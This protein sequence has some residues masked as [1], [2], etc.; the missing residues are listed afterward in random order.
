VG[1][2]RLLHE[3]G[4]GGQAV[5]WLAEDTRIGRRVALK[6]LPELGPGSEA[7]L[8][9]FRREAE[10]TSRLEHPAICPV[11]EADLARG[12]PFIA[13][14]FVDGETLA[15]RIART[16]AAGSGPVALTGESAPD[17]TGIATFF[18]RIARALHLAHEAGVV[19]R[20]IKPANLM[21]T[22]Q[23]EPVILDFGL[24]R[25]DD[26][27]SH[28]LTLSAQQSGT[29][30]YM[31]PEQMTGRARPDRRSDVYSLGCTLFECL[32][33]RPP[34]VAPTLEALFHAVLHDD[35]PDARGL[36]RGIPADLAVITATA[37][38]K[39]PE[40]RYKTALDMALDLERFARMEPIAA[41]PV[42][43]LQRA[44]R[45]SRRNQALAASLGAVL[46]LLML[47]TVLLSYGLGASGRAELETQLRLQAETQRAEAEGARQRMLQASADRDFTGRLDELLLKHGTLRFGVQGGEEAVG[48]LLPAYAALLREAGIDLAAPDAAAKGREAVEKLRARDS[49]AAR[50]LLDGIRNMALI[51]S[52]GDDGRRVL[53]QI[54]APFED[55]RIAAFTSARGKW[56]RERVDEFGPLLTEPLLDSLDADQLAEVG[57]ML[58]YVEGRE[59]EGLE[60]LD[61][62]LMRRPDSFAIHF[63]RAGM[64]LGRA[65]VGGGA[66]SLDAA[67]KAVEHFRVAM[68]L[69]PRSGLTRAALAAALA[70]RAQLT[71]AFE[72]FLPA[73]RLME[74]ATEVEPDN[75]L[76]WFLRGD[77]L[78]R[79]P[80]GK[81]AA[82]QACRKALELDPHLA[83]AQ[84]MLRELGG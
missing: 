83:P 60:L 8:R 47:A 30:T 72:E 54:V 40:R 48:S 28:A 74:S 19:H 59:A 1:A 15:R 6:L 44:M 23:G 16:A 51:P 67:N 65:S 39:E 27:D 77:Y 29:P 4:R 63:M 53:V 35:L 18:A 45:W 57:A 46:V 84:A 5:V 36:Q 31:S 79:T 12:V 78:R 21:V 71:G 20:D 49:D 62:A 80:N 2:Y 11:Y 76:V 13:M 9:R 41:R 73:W 26:K 43:H 25:Q 66:K 7:V 56:E 32:T 14:R 22:P 52:L 33:G 3:I 55:R 75:G 17:W 50:A 68:A 42:T 38:A 81:A 69:R 10:V 70:M 82:V 24:A 58:A 61:R 64:S 37:G 34:F